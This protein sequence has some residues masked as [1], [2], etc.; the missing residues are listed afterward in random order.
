VAFREINAATL[1]DFSPPSSHECWWFGFF[2]SGS[3][4]WSRG[5]TGTGEHALIVQGEEGVRAVGSP[6]RSSRVALVRLLRAAQG[7]ES[8]PGPPPVSHMWKQVDALGET[9]G[10]PRM[11]VHKPSQN[12]RVGRERAQ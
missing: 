5:S 6:A 7:R 2:F 3:E 11:S 8:D 12:K 4:V 9:D 10:G 1:L